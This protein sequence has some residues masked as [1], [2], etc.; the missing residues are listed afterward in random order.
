[1]TKK[2][3]ALAVL[4]QGTG[5]HPASWME[6]GARRDLATDIDYYADLAAIA[7]R[8]RFDLFFIADTP[9]ARTTDL[10]AWSRFPLFMN[11]FEPVTLLS[12]LSART[13]RIGLGATASTSFYEPYNVA[14]L[15]ASLDHLSH[16]RAAWNVVT[17]ANDFAARN[18]GLDMLPPHDDRYARAR[19]FLEVV[20]A[21]WDT[22]EDDA[23][24]NDLDAQL[25]F[26][27]EKFHPIAH[28]G[29]HFRVNGGLNI[30]R[31]PQGRPVI[32]QAGASEA[33]KAFAAEHAEVA[34]GIADTVDKGKR[35]YADLKGR[36]AA[37]GRHPDELKL[38][39]GMSV[40]VGDT[41]AEAEA[42]FARQQARIHPI[43]GVMRISADLETDLSDLPLDE[44]VPVERIPQTSNLHQAYF[45]NI[46]G[47]IRSG[48]TLREVA[49]AY[50][51]GRNTFCG[52]PVEVADHLEAWIDEGAADGFMMVLPTMPESLAAFVD[53]VVPELQRRGRVRREYQ[54]TTLREHLG[55]ARPPHPRARAIASAAE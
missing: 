14:R 3:M 25:Y 50:Q 23:F 26:D 15:F 16:G 37:F 22:W 39:A 32:I 8:G 5:A 53:K 36:M 19:E 17:S 10:H 34:F 11:V 24:V 6:T 47:M 13:S 7:E 2:T 45:D 41:K 1:M 4:V 35:F 48:M 28:E 42:E 43:V 27:P 29:E 20:E 49:M 44:P 31:P 9:G 40:V 18:F 46:A 30:A 21:L 54:G 52:S 12:A 33:G 38:L 55:L 51:R